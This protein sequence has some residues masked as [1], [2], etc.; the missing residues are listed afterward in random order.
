MTV[1][2][3]AALMIDSLDS[4]HGTHQSSIVATLS[5]GTLSKGGSSKSFPSTVAIEEYY[6]PWVTVTT[7]AALMIDSRETH[8]SSIVAAGTI[9]LHTVWPH[10]PHVLKITSHW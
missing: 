5:D 3:V 9:H 8:Q 6:P 7:V 4:S 2:T 10:Q 1:T